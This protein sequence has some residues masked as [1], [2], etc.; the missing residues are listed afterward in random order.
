MKE[1]NKIVTYMNNDIWYNI[2]SYV[3]YRE[4]CRWRRI[5]RWIKGLVEEYQRNVYEE[6]V[7][8]IQRVYRSYMPMRG[9]MYEKISQMVDKQSYIYSKCGQTCNFRSTLYYGTEETDK[10][11][12]S[13]EGRR[14]GR[15]L[16]CRF[17]RMQIDRIDLYILYQSLQYAIEYCEQNY[18]LLEC[19]ERELV[20]WIRYGMEHERNLVYMYRMLYNGVLIPYMD[21][22]GYGSL[23]HPR[24]VKTHTIFFAYMEY[25]K[26]PYRIMDKIWK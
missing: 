13:E 21:R 19:E 11:F 14:F 4:Q 9:I 6:N 25:L 5:D 23:L 18:D 20:N 24:G 26:Y 17:I 1:W 16:I 3:D 8:K 22:Y 2:C 7:K 10:Y 15:Q 12:R